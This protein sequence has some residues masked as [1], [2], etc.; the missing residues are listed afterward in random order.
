MKKSLIEFPK[1]FEFEPKIQNSPL[2][3]Y[4]RYILLGMGGSHL[5]ADIL[6]GYDPNIQLSVHSNYG[7]PFVP[8]SERTQ[9]LIIASSFS[10]NT[11]EVIDGLENALR[12]K[13]SVVIIARGGKLIEIA[14]KK[15]LPYIQFPDE[16]LQPRLALG[17][18]LQALLK[19]LAHEKGLR[20]TALLAKKLDS[21]KA[22]QKAQVLSKKIIGSVPII[23]TSNRNRA[24]G[25]NWKIKTN[26]TGKIPAFY[27]V[28][29]EL[30]HNE[31]NGFDVKAQNRK[32]SSQFHF[33]FITDD[34]DS[35]PIKKRFAILEKLYKARKLPVTIVPLRGASRLEQIFNSLMIADWLS[36]AIATHYGTEAEQVPM[37]EEFKRMIDHQTRIG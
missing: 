28:L 18:S 27:N 34:T 37:V 35:A 3:K 12:Q 33:I 5:A 4:Q 9:T 15:K 17:Y 25:Y 1:Q 10:G 16:D 7:L 23:Y 8:D 2:G 26:E 31:M 32:L 14:R 30:N 36:L 6:K 24:I 19:V 13:L 29:P 11:E 22:K 20:E 21:S